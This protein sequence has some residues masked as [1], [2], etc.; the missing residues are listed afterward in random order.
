MPKI[1]L[2]IFDLDGTLVDSKQDISNAINFML[3]ELGML[4]KTSDEIISYVGHGILELIDRSLRPREVELREKGLGIF[5]RYYKVHSADYAC[6]YPGVKDTLDYFKSKQMAVITNRN[7]NSSVTI[8]KK[9]SIY[10]YFADVIGDDNTNCL[11]PS[12]CQF[13]KLLNKKEIKDRK[14]VIMVGDMDV[15]I[16]A[17]R[18]SGVITCV[19][20]YGFG[21]KKD[22][23]K[24]KPD[25]MID[26]IS[27]L[28]DIIV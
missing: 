22:L 7:Y 15:D 25:Y 19:T 8:L 6:L 10:P 26:D 14:K 1:E 5:K 2:I 20:T 24:A 9:L 11:K 12:R 4:Q 28:K 18:A 3:D 27:K 17:G 13:D 23:E 16:I 21:E